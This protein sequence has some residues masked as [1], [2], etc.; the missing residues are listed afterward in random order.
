MSPNTL[1]I[2][3]PSY[4]EEK[5]ILILLNRILDVNLINGIN[6]EIIIVD[7][8]S[9]DN[10]KF[11][12]NDYI[13]KSPEKNITLLVHDKNRGKGA[14]V[15]TGIKHVT[16]E[17]VIIQDGDLECDPEDYNPLLKELIEKEMLVVF[18]SRFQTKE[19]KHLSKWFYIGGKVIT[20]TA[21]ILYNQNLT[22]EAACYKMFRTEFLKS[23]PLQCNRFEFCPEITAKVAKRGI[24]ISEV[25]I[26]FYPRT[27]DEGKKIRAK[28][29]FEAIWTLIKYKFVN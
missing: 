16:G 12:V 19:N 27:N 18:G 5:T 7:D 2:I 4:N 3:I 28:D 8:G 9:C 10:T 29:G 24:K 21:N 17:F 25:P 22:D 15:R 11:T 1:S 14:A 23:I 20:H 13:Q 6:K 26:R